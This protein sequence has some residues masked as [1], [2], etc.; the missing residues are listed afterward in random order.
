MPK[1]SFLFIDEP[2]V[3]LHPMWQKTLI[4]TLYE[5]SKN[6]VNIVIASHSIDIMKCIENI[7]ERLPDNELS[8]HFGINQ[9]NING[10]SV[11][12]SK[13]NLR[14]LSSIKVDLG[15]AFYEMFMD[16]HQTWDDE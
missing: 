13:N 1:G 5:L 7:M 9:L 16:N 4:E 12:S 3:H 14:Q 6:G 2:E 15:E 10:E 11:E 8:E